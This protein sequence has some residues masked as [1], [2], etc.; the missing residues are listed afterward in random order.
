MRSPSVSANNAADNSSPPPPSPPNYRNHPMK[1]CEHRSP[2]H[3]GFTL[4]E[5]LTVIAIIGILSM[6]VVTTVSRVRRQADRVT[7]TSNLRQIGTAMQL[8]MNERK[9]GKFPG[10]LYS[11]QKASTTGGNGQLASPDRLLPYMSGQTIERDGVKYAILLE[12]PAWK[13]IIGADDKLKNYSAYYT[14][15]NVSKAD[16]NTGSVFGY[17][18][19]PQDPLKLPWTMQDIASPSRAWVLVDLDTGIKSGE[20]YCIDQIAHG[21]TRNYLFADGHVAASKTKL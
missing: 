1:T 15:A 13:K 6:L 7:C 17:K 2:H 21:N 3:F 16:G 4:I 12:C 8:Y 5:L 11:N 14:N 9:D 20:N 18:A 19:D 10:P